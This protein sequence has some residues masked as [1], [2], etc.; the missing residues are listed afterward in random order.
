MK[1]SKEVLFTRRWGGRALHTWTPEP[2]LDPCPQVSLPRNSSFQ[3]PLLFG[4]PRPFLPTASSTVPR[5][6]FPKSDLFIQSRGV[7]GG[8]WG[9]EGGVAMNS[10]TVCPENSSREGWHPK[11]QSLVQIKTQTLYSLHPTHTHITNTHTHTP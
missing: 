1:T 5:S 6:T 8:G 10:S 4:G 3:P 11:C 2:N 9:M 7:L